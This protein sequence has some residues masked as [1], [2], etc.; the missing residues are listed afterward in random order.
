MAK[1]AACSPP[2]ARSTRSS[3]PA[4]CSD[5]AWPKPRIMSRRSSGANSSSNALEEHY[6]FSDESAPVEAAEVVG[7]HAHL[8]ADDL[9][10]MAVI[11]RQIDGECGD[12]EHRECLDLNHATRS[13]F[14]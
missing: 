1:S 5:S 2:T 3:A 11:G 9:A 4:R 8:V 13:P 14:R 6:S 12:D 10:I 7:D